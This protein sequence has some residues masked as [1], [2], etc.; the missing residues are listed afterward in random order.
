MA[1]PVLDDAPPLIAPIPFSRVRL[2]D[3]AASDVVDVLRSGWLTTG[4]RVLCFEADFAEFVGA[5]RA[6]AVSSCTAALELSLKA[7]RLPA[8]SRV[9]TTTDTFCGTVAAILHAGLT[10]V[11]ADVDPVTAMPSA[12]S[13]ARVTDEVGGVAAMV[14]VHLA[15]LPAPVSE[16]AAAAGLGLDR[17]IEDAAH[18]L[19][20]WVD[21][22]PVGAISRATCFSFYATKN[23]PIG[24]G[25]MITTDDEDL[26]HTLVQTRLHGLSADAW[27]RYRPGASWR[28][29]VNE[30][31]IKANMT[32]VQAAIGLAGLHEFPR[33]QQRRA[34][35]AARYD[36]GLADIPGLCL[37][38]RPARGRHAW[39]LYAVRVRPGFGRDRDA[40]A[41]ELTR[42][43]IGNSVHFIPVHQLTAFRSVCL[44]PANGW[45]NAERVHAETLSLPMDSVISDDEVTRVCTAVRELGVPS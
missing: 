3:D 36:A 22:R 9:L 17:V 14:V 45:P 21:D 26:A 34:E 33:M 2:S 38:L 5:R 31:G 1:I 42:R 15:G 18:A 12:E 41:E 35:V 39:H 16:L 44:G 4:E 11:L 32:D 43:G 6:I 10:P 8:G 23:L 13:V 27:R 24:E 40:L 29:D 37:P 28:Y 30:V 19:G 7:L 20:T 25:G